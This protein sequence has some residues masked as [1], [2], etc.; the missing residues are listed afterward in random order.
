MHINHNKIHGE[1]DIM[2]QIQSL[3]HFVQSIVRA[4]SPANHHGVLTHGTILQLLL[5]TVN[6]K[7]DPLIHEIVQ[8][9]WD[10]RH[11]HHHA[12]LQKTR[13]SGSRS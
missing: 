4:L 3:H 13:H 5:K 6:D 9:G 1:H 10:T 2:N 8:V 12:N 7:R 11:F